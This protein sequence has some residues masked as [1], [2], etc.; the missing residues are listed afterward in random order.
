MIELVATNATN[1][2][3]TVDSLIG[4]I[5]TN[6][7]S[8]VVIAIEFL[9]G[10]ALGYVAM[11][12]LKYVLAAMGVIFLGTLLGVWSF[13][14]SIQD[15]F[16]YILSIAKQIWNFVYALL[17]ALGLLVM[18]PVTLGFVVGALIAHLRK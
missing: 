7:S 2:T 18:G 10:L 11:K 9:L 4:A 1:A 15:T 14:R 8:F 5:I 16:G 12:A 17:A 13:G 3:P 6:P